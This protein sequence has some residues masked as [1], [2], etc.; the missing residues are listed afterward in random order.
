M[1]KFSPAAMLKIPAKTQR[2]MSALETFS[3]THQAAEKEKEKEYK[4]KNKNKNEYKNKKANKD[5]TN[6]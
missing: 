2:A 1:N 6:S 5:K 4:N 3:T